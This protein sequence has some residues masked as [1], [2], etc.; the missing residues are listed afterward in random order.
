MI[1]ST[2]SNNSSLFDFIQHFFDVFDPSDNFP[3]FFIGNIVKSGQLGLSFFTSD[4]NHFVL[5]VERHSTPIK[6]VHLKY[7]VI[8]SEHDSMFGFEPLP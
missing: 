4:Q 8:E 3:I 2:L 6:E 5:C 1:S 7:F